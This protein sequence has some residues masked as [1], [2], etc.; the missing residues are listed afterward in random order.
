M[1]R[2]R[3]A[4]IFGYVCVISAFNALLLYEGYLWGKSDGIKQANSNCVSSLEEQDQKKDREC[5]TA[6]D[7][8]IQACSETCHEECLLEIHRSCPLI[9]GKRPESL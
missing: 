3:V 2:D 4:K 1:S 7:G 8:L 6:I 9:N 5:S